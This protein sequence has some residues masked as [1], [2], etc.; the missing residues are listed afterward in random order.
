MV[1]CRGENRK[2]WRPTDAYV[3]VHKVERIHT[4]RLE[5]G[6]G[7]GV[8]NSLEKAMVSHT[9]AIRWIFEIMNPWSVRTDIL[10]SFWNKFNQGNDLHTIRWTE[11]RNVRW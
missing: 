11:N 4:R 1:G 6:T 7:G 5:H 10:L 3:S 9:Q 8:V 2:G